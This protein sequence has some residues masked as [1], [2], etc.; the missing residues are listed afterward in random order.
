MKL[1]LNSELWKQIYYNLR[2]EFYKRHHVSANREEIR[3]FLE[4][5]GVM[6]QTEPFSKRWES[7]EIVLDEEEL[8]LFLLRW[9]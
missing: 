7:V 8:T 3:E 2:E 5:Y 6:I 9:S 4:E 1:A